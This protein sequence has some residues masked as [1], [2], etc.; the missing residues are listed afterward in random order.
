MLTGIAPVLLI[1]FT[2][3][4][5]AFP[6]TEILL[7]FL[8]PVKVKWIVAAIVG[9]TLLL[10]LSHFDISH[11][12]LYLSAVLIA[13]GYAVMVQGWYSPF[14]FTLRFDI[15]LSRLAA[16][17]KERKGRLS[18]PR[19]KLS[20]LRQDSQ[21]RM[22]KLLWMPCLLKSLKRA[23]IRL[24]GLRKNVCRKFQKT[25]C[26]I[27]NDNLKTPFKLDFLKQIDYNKLFL[28]KNSRFYERISI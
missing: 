27:D 16:R 2:V 12:I 13:Y 23:K 14:P 26:A 25:K 22:T 10:S 4:S 3:W 21:L 1:L 11:F 28:I 15:W 7:L 8:I 20:I 9:I 17:L 19:Q 6:E 18:P 24:P 5:M